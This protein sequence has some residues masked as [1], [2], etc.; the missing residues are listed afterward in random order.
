ML[1]TP[2]IKEGDESGYR[3]LVNNILVYG[4][5]NDLILN[6][7]KTKEIILDFRKNPPP[8]QPLII[9]GSEVE[10][11]DSHRFLGLQVT[12]DLSWALNT[13]VAVKKAQR[14]LYFIRLLRKAGLSSRPLT[15]AY[16]G[17]TESILTT[18]ITVCYGN[19]TQA[20][21]KALQ[22]VIK[23]AEGVVGTKRPSMES[24]YVQRC[25]REGICRD[26]AHPAHSLLRLKRCTYNLRHSRADNQIS[27]L[28]KPHRICLVVP[29]LL[30]QSCGK[31]A[32]RFM[33]LSLWRGYLVP[34]KQ[35]LRVESSFSYLEISSIR[36]HSLTQ[37]VLET[38]R[39]S[40]SFSMLQ[41][42]DL[43]AV[44][45]HVTASLKRIFPDSSPG[46]LLKTVPQDLQERL[47][48]LTSVI[49]EQLNSQPAPCG[50]FSDTYAALCDFNEIPF[51]E[52]IQWDVD[53]IYYKHNWSTFNLLDFSHLDSR[54]LALAV[55]ALS[56]NQWFT[57]I[58]CKDLKLSI[59]VQQQLM[60]LLSKSSCLQE[61]SVENCGLKL[62]FAIKMTA[63]LQENSSSPLQSINLSGNPI[64]DKEESVTSQ[65]D[66]RGMTF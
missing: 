16:R 19:T 4:E 62:D 66:I 8:L 21:R 27:E 24:L 50:G 23:T 58:Y 45:S 54:D 22:R 5:E 64:E 34:N 10:R 61:L 57:T 42:E 25:Q 59:E 47:V 11:P 36:I 49:E 39:Q 37:I 28:L 60:F 63:A 43:E 31:S 20:E 33:V 18:S 15:Q 41:D 7:D 40:L 12:S 38:D 32:N 2:L 51:R 46:K 53:N 3:S 56:F 55:A 65:F 17:L 48:T 52:E 29:V 9:R 14:R 1:T 6:T 13:E 35:P 44:I 26:P 30:H